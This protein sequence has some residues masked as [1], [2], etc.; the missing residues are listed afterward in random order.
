V[1]GG[2]IAV[3]LRGKAAAPTV[4]V[5]TGPHPRTARVS[6]ART[7]DV[8]ER[9]SIAELN[10]LW[11]TNEPVTLVDARADRSLRGDPL[12]A[13][14]AVRLPPDDAVRTATQIGLSHH[15]TLVIY[16]A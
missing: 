3:F 2:G 10:E 5:S 16:C 6:I 8:P 13:T 14:G 7:E 9:V 1:H 12:Q 11:S 15:G 4:G